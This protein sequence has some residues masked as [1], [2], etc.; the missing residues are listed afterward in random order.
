MR[1]LCELLGWLVLSTLS[2]HSSIGGALSMGRA[3]S[4]SR[5]GVLESC[6]RRKRDIATVSRAHCRNFEGFVARPMAAG[7]SRHVLAWYVRLHRR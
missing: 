5:Y 2:V 1:G 4:L 6:S 7:V 3:G